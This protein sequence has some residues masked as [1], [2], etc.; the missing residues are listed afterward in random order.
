MGRT[1]QQYKKL[2][3]GL[4]SQKPQ[5]AY[6]LYG[7][8]EFIKKEFIGELT[9]TVLPEKERTFNLDVFHGDEFNRDAFDDCLSA[10]PLF[11]ER[12]MLVL[13]KF[14]ALSSSLQDFVIERVE[15]AP[16]SL[17]LVIQ[18]DREKLD[19]ARLQ[20]LART[21]D[22]VGVSF[23]FRFLS[24]EETVERVKSRLQRENLGIEPDALDLLIAS[25]G[26]QLS[27]LGN[28]LEKIILGSADA[29]VI[30]RDIVASVV[31]RYRAESLFAFLDELG[32]SDVGRLIRRV[33]RVLDGGE[34]PVFV[35]AMLIRRVLLLL[36]VK[37]LIQE[38][39]TRVR[40]S[41]AMAARL[42]GGTSPFYA[43]RLIEQAGRFDT[44]VLTGYLNNL[45]WADLKLKSSSIPP[46]SLI[47][48]SLVASSLRK[49][50]A[51]S[52]I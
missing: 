33:N 51:Q 9:R 37:Y 22:R 24:D 26:T 17:V 8:E 28:E 44:P 42:P 25:V 35:L 27:D 29:K 10:F 32:Q 13:R 46:R 1:L 14:E 3:D 41:A 40:S 20:K 16:E 4:K 2:F 6:F 49:N 15:R 50:L 45:R 31:G 36:Q 48:A 47:E 12:R 43:A 52:A 30:T 23:C 38:E 18:S 5:R 34:E 39:G 11:M 7:P 19:T 21:V